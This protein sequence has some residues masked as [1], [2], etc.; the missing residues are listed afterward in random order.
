MSTSH[1]RKQQQKKIARRKALKK[2]KQMSYSFDDPALIIE[3]PGHEKMSEVLEDFAAPYLDQATT[4]DAYDRVFTAAVVA[5]NAALV[6]AAKRQEV[7]DIAL[8]KIPAEERGHA[9]L[10]AFLQELIHRKERLYPR[11][12]RAILDYLL[13]PLPDGGFHLNVVSTLDQ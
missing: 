11:N 4:F 1:R 2:K 13:T 7:I 3:P 12:R 9:E 6:S 10:R 8:A 5:W